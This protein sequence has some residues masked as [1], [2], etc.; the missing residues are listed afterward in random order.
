VKDA[1]LLALK[2]RRNTHLLQINNNSQNIMMD[3]ARSMLS[4]SSG[5]RPGT[6]STMKLRGNN[7]EDIAFMVK[8]LNEIANMNLSLVSFDELSHNNELLPLL[9]QVLLLVS[10][11]APE[12][13]VDLSKE[14][15]ETTVQRIGHFLVNILGL[16]VVKQIPPYV[17]YCDIIVVY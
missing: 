13:K 2:T 10:N 6:T 7:S 17:I 11:N 14:D 9:Q 8:R 15:G 1:I 3:T 4:S 16:K 12:M 5:R